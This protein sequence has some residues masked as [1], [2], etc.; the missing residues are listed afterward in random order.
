MVGRERCCRDVSRGRGRRCRRTPDCR[1]RARPPT[2]VPRP[3][4]DAHR[5]PRPGRRCHRSPRRRSLDAHGPRARMHAH[6]Y[7]DGDLSGRRAVSCSLPVRLNHGCAFPP[8]QLVEHN[9]SPVDAQWMQIIALPLVSRSLGA[10]VRERHA[11]GWV[12][13]RRWHDIGE[14]CRPDHGRMHDGHTHWACRSGRSGATHLV[15][16]TSGDLRA[17]RLP[18]RFVRPYELARGAQRR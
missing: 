6:R 7:P 3:R 10:G 18:R 9:L 1:L 15:W 2:A 8:R 5:R 12:R 17:G 16:L 11:R 14:A 13:C 4:C